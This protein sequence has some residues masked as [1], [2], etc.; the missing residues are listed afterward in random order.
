MEGKLET[1]MFSYGV[2]N[3]SRLKKPVIINCNI[4]D[5]LTPTF[6]TKIVTEI[7]KY[8]FCNKLIPYPYDAL[9][10]V[11]QNLHRVS[12]KSMLCLYVRILCR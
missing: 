12:N 2:S 9:R 4:G 5:T 1:E 7:A 11:A 3:R 6:C 8:I 10:N